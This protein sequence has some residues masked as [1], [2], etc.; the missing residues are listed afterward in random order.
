M[1]S[2]AIGIDIGGG[3]CRAARISDNGEILQFAECL[4]P[5]EAQPDAL[6]SAI[7]QLV[8]RVRSAADEPIGLALPGIVDEK[9]GVMI[10][11]VN[12]PFL[13][14]LN[15]REHFDRA[16][17]RLASLDSDVN[18]AAL[19]QFARLPSPPRAMVYLSLG[20]GV[21]GSVIVDGRLLRH[22]RNG[23]GNLGHLTIDT[24]DDAPLCPCGAR[25]CLE[26][27]ASGRAIDSTRAVVGNANIV[28]IVATALARACR[29]FAV[30][31][32]PE[33][34]LIGGG[35]VD[36]SNGRTAGVDLISETRA[37]Y[38]RFDSPL[39]PATLRIER[40]PL[41]SSH[42]G[43]TGAALQARD[44]VAASRST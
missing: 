2:H 12:L 1:F 27:V 11:A 15:V 31:F 21:G 33:L 40:A 13:D 9:T 3:H 29:Q 17:G 5:L 20:T 35:V 36:H 30:L 25:G 44:A 24:A 34:I 4:T 32:A 8:D 14:G 7:R 43:V 10:R 38:R 37:R 28:G 26:A 22:A 18:A 16:V 6:F 23:A 39:T 19:A 42:A 41:P